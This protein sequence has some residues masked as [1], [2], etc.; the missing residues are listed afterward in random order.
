MANR[1]HSDRS[2]SFRNLKV[3]K[4]AKEKTVWRS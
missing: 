4:I 3:G 2:G 1:M